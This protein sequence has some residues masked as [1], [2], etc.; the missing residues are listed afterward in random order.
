VGTAALLVLATWFLDHQV[1][2]F[3][4]EGWVTRFT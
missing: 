4:S 1:G 2:R 3:R